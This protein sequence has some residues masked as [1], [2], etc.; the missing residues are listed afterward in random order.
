MTH[1]DQEVAIRIT[2]K[3]HAAAGRT[4]TLFVLALS[5]GACNEF[6]R[7]GGSGPASTGVSTPDAAA[8]AAD[9]AIV[10][11]DKEAALRLF[12]QAIEVNPQFVRAHMGMADI[13]RLDGDYQKAE[14]AY[15]KAAQVEPRNFDAQ[16]YHGLMLHVLNRVQEAISAYLRALQVKP[17]DF[18][19]NLNISAAY[20]QIGESTQGVFYAQQAVKLKPQDGPA[21]MNLGTIYAE[22]G[23][24]REAI[25][26]YQQAAELMP[27]SP[28][29]LTNLADSLGRLSRFDEMRNT[30]EQL[31]KTKPTPLAHERLGF[32]LVKLKLFPDAKAS[33]QRALAMDP[34]YYPALNGLGVCELYS[35][36]QSDR[37]DVA[38]KER[39]QEALR[40]SLLISRKQPKIEELLGRYK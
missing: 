35:Y 40:R 36:L 31:V 29:L 28:A 25:G 13:Y 37:A 1:T 22:V 30:L 23:K 2:R 27:L 16:Y 14:S 18:Q 39:A 26:E 8:N 17:D 38:A 21:R 4:A 32:A 19:A 20:Y 11:G 33:F 10:K 9:A 12:A 3:K 34:D 6:G 7:S 24:D 15:A 5:L